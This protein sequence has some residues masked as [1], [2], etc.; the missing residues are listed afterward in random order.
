MNMFLHELKAYGK[1]TMIW[2]FALSAFSIFFLSMYPAF[3]TDV[4]A[5][6]KFLENYPEAVRKAIGLTIDIFS[7]VIGFYSYMF[8]YIAL[9]GCIQAM[10]YGVSA[11][12]KEAREKTADFL[13]TKPV[14]RKQ[15]ITA[16]L[17][18]ILTSIV[19]TDAIYII[20][21]TV[22]ASAVSKTSFDMK[23]F[24]MIS[25]TLFFMQLM[26]MTLGVLI[27]VVLPKIRSVIAV[28]LSTV[29]GFFIVGMLESIIESEGLRYLIPF[30][31]YDTSYI[32]KNSSYETSFIITEIIFIV[33]SI[34]LSYLIYSKKDIHAV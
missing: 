33:V 24:I 26:F 11:L 14:T 19:I 30:K 9:C 27:S 28:S 22:M 12:S 23:I 34:A 21:S 8:F 25:L 5:M 20:V 31:Y 18:A 2:I 7:S 3:S 13:L 4:D 10:N 6:K 16:K 32:I 1:S 29:F 15:I 17:C